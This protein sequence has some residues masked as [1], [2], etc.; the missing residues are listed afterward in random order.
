M[1]TAPYTVPSTEAKPQPSQSLKR[2]AD[3]QKTNWQKKNVS[4]P[5]AHL[6]GQSPSEGNIMSWKKSEVAFIQ[7]IKHPMITTLEAPRHGIYYVYCQIGFEGKDGNLLLLSQVITWD[8]LL[9]KNVTTLISG[10]ES[11]TG[12]PLH[13]R[14]WHAS[15]TLGRL[16]NL[17]KGQKLHVHVSHPEL[18]DYTAGKTFFGMVMVS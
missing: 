1:A 4:W 12:P 14:T 15:L 2:K 6:I 10:K 5:A 11:V 3:T 8:N 16:A 18:V 9:D 17:T 7:K 13:Q